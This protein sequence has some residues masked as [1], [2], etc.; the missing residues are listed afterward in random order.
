MMNNY[1]KCPECG[2]T[3]QRLGSMAPGTHIGDTGQVPQLD[4]DITTCSKCGT[5]LERRI[6]VDEPWQRVIESP[7]SA[8]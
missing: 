6:G 4:R 1:D 3:V 8:P 2:A 7:R 5:R